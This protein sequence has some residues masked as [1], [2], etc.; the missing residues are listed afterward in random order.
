MNAVMIGDKKLEIPIIQGGMGVGV[1][2]CH[3]AGAVAKEGAMGVISSAQIG[4]TQENFEKHPKES[5]LDELSKQIKRA[6][7]ISQGHGLV[8]VNIMVALQEYEDQ[9]K[10]SCAAG[11]DAIISGAGLP[12]KLPEYVEGSNVKIA[13]IVSSKKSADVILHFWDH[14]YSRTADFIVIE[15]PKA[16][17]HLGFKREELDHIEELNYD[18]VVKDILTVV[19]TYEEKFEKKIPVFLAGGIVTR[20]DA[21]HAASLGVDGIQVAS[22]FVATNECDASDAYKNAYI[23]AKEEDI[24]II[25]S[26]VGMPGR[27]IRNPFVEKVSKDKEKITFCYRCLH[28]CNPGTA[29]YCITKALVNAVEGNL[30]EGLIFCGART[31]E[32]NKIETVADVIRDLNV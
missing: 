27:A 6:K 28:G 9:V 23:Q 25:K 20:E 2:R 26:P 15:G 11:V 32:I 24:V 21:E 1:S 30:D 22:R 18:Q 13:P 14:K 16:G 7:E 4:Y 19:K 8:A 5:N 3:L 10:T 29:P 12:S 31:G 17:G